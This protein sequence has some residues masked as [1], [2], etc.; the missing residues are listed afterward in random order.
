MSAPETFSWLWIWVC[1]FLT[2]RRLLWLLM[3]FC[4]IQKWR[5]TRRRIAQYRD[6]HDID[7]LAAAFM[8]MALPFF[9]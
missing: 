3:S 7:G 9:R 2:L 5:S 4:G 6:S 1:M 8:A